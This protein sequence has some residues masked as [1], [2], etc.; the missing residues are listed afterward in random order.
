MGG[1]TEHATNIFYG[2]K[3]VTAG[4][5]PVVHETAHQWFGDAVTESDW[6]DVWLSEG[7]A[8]YFTL[9]YTEHA[10]GRDAFLAGLR[11]S[12]NGVLQLEK[13]QPN[14]PVVH[15]KFDESGADG[16][17]NQLVYQKGGWTLH[18]L[19]EQIGTDA[20]WR[21]IRLYYQAHMNGLASTADLRGAMEQ[22][23]GQDLSWFFRQWLTRSGVPIVEGTWR[24]DAAARQVVVT[25]TQV[26]TADPYRFQMGVGIIQSTG[27]AP[28]VVYAQVT[29]RETSIAIPADAAPAS[30]VFDPNVALLAEIRQPETRR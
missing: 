6:N 10:A 12:R 19:R 28:R 9:L 27:A 20:F 18:M 13:V 29:G 23:S 2:E 4:N 17:N 30:V 22:A 7:F 8:T 1:G 26:Q 3:G 25:I 21:G 5:A 16:P 24:Y 14:T 11:R 15:V